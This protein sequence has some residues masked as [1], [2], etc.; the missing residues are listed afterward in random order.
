MPAPD[1]VGLQSRIG[2]LF[3]PRAEIALVREDYGGRVEV[4]CADGTVA[5][6]PGP[7]ESLAGPPWI[8][9][10]DG[11]L[12]NPR[13]LRR[14]RDVL[15]VP[16][17]GTIPCPPDWPVGS[18]IRHPREP[19]P[20]PIHFAGRTLDR[21]RL[22]A[23]VRQDRDGHHRILMADG[24]VTTVGRDAS[25]RLRE[26]LGLE[27]LDELR[28]TS[29]ALRWLYREGVRDWPFE[30]YEAPAATLRRHFGTDKRLLM[31][32]TVWQVYR[33]RLAGRPVHYGTS[34]RG[35]WYVPVVDVLARAGLRHEATLLE[36]LGPVEL[37]GGFQD[38]DYRAF[39]AILAQMI[40]EQRLFTYRDLGVV[41][42]RPDLHAV[43]RVDPRVVLYVE[44]SSLQ[45]GVDAIVERHGPSHVVMG[46]LSTY[47][48]TEFFV[49][50][51]HAAGV[52]GPLQIVAYVDF[53]PAGWAGAKAFVAHLARYGVEVAHLGYII[54]PSR[55]TKAE[56]HLHALPLAAPDK[57]HAAQNANWV[58]E[59]G[60][61]GGKPMG[62]HADNFWP[63]TRAV[64]AY[65]E[66][67]AAA[68]AE[69]PSPGP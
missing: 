12:A 31:V 47:E 17:G 9:L 45:D 61:V 51:L 50:S 34:V 20:D 42:P 16:G 23:I 56:L 52:T 18:P 57:T 68:S 44:K 59:S 24:K 65:E 46:G 35:L 4:T 26:A 39:E 43:G 60:G 11:A 66:E 54:R 1:P 69:R 5:H 8:R 32:H 67:L 33:Y 62:I 10:P 64:Q 15:E 21:R 30:L 40:G 13:H 28:P 49:A 22:C 19:S 63:M 14:G 3:R 36:T 29:D 41:D 25:E 53:D 58:R 48:T 37:Y 2:L 38:P 55:F 27:S 7:L 6:R